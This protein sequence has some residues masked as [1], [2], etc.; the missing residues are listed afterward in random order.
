MDVISEA[1][2]ISSRTWPFS[3]REMASVLHKPQ[4]WPKLGQQSMSALSY[5]RQLRVSGRI[6]SEKPT[7]RY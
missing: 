1:L 5:S 7:Y 3:N 2:H 4:S 6:A